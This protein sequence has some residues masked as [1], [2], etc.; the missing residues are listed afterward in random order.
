MNRCVWICCFGVCLIGLGPIGC[1][2][3]EVETVYGRT[4]GKSINGTGALAEL[5]RGQGHEVRVAIRATPTLGEWADVLIRFAE[6]PGTLDR[7][8]AQWFREW[9]A[10]EPGRKLVY[11][12]YDFDAEPEFWAAMLTALPKGTPSRIVEQI[13]QKRD[14]SQSWASRLPPKPKNQARVDDWFGV[15]TGAPAPSTCKTLGGPWAEGVDVKA[16]ALTKHDVFTSKD[17]EEILLSGDDQPLVLGWTQ[18]NGSSVLALANASFVVNSALMVRAR[19]PLTNRVLEWVGAGASHVAF[20]EGSRLLAKEDNPA[21]SPLDLIKVR[22]FGWVMGQLAGFGILFALALAATLGRPRAEPPSEIE[23]PSAH[24]EALGA[25]LAKTRRADVALLMLET[26]RRWR[27][28]SGRV[29]PKAPKT[30]PTS[31]ST[32]TPTPPR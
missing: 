7:D 23:H 4:R 24:P 30:T 26:Y 10:G 18:D 1:G 27:H 6:H 11:I 12:P 3:R 15:P 17:E 2:P 8:E 5:L 20:L 21:N 13:E 31:T 16:A 19:R 22:P 32:S 9:L 28:P 14:K 25:L 29:M